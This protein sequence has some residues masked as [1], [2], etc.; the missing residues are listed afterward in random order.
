MS[1]FPTEQGMPNW[2]PDNVKRP[3]SEVLKRSPIELRVGSH[4]VNKSEVDD[5]RAIIKQ[6][7]RPILIGLSGSRA[8]LLRTPLFSSEE[9]FLSYYE[10]KK[11][12]EG[13]LS[14]YL[15]FGG[16]TLEDFKR[17][18]DLLFKKDF[19]RQYRA[20][21]SF[22]WEMVRLLVS[23]I[24]LLIIAEGGIDSKTYEGYSSH[25][26]IDVG[27]H[28][29]Y[30]KFDTHSEDLQEYIQRGLYQTIPLKY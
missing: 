14:G 7:Q 15:R 30:N 10:R 12:E 22:P 24:D 25:V 5:V 13:N 9:G 19:N 4:F 26:S 2:I 20:N 3:L 23:D 16:L 28:T 8:N 18:T 29:P 21:K 27:I 11:M 17:G 6:I 1:T